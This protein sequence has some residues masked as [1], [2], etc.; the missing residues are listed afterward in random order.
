R[1]LPTLSLHDA[2][3]ISP[4]GAFL[5]WQPLLTLTVPSLAPR[6]S[7]VVSGSAWAPQ[8]APVARPE[9][10]WYLS[11]RLLRALAEEADR[12][13]RAEAEDRKS[14]RLNSSHQII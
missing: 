9:E 2:L 12:E 6:S 1:P 5:T 3:P 7:T 13:A 14:T 4:L 11:P 10:A 8:P